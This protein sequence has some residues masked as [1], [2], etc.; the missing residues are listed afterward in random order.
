MSEKSTRLRGKAQI[1][2]SEAKLPPYMLSIAPFCFDPS[3][4]FLQK[5]IKILELSKSM[6]KINDM[7]DASLP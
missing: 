6:L 1:D 5:K 2:F 7:G 3:L 4:V